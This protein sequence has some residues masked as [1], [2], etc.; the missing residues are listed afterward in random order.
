MPKTSPHRLRPQR[1]VAPVL[2]AL[3][4]AYGRPERGER[5][6]LEVLVRGILS[7]NTTDTN[8]GRAYRTLRERMPRWSDVAAADRRRIACAIRCGGLA[9]QKA[10]AI[11]N[12]MR[13]LRERDERSLDFLCD[14]GPEDAE[15]QLS[16]VKG[17]G[18]KTARLVLLFGFGW[19]VFVVDTHVHRVARRLGL[20]PDAASREKAHHL[21]DELIPDGDKYAAHLEM[22]RHGRECCHA[23]GPE[24][25]GCPVRR[26]CVFVR[27]AG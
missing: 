4:A 19:P 13:W 14:L 12:V 27:T 17:V 23:R 3:E 21:L 1:K 5:E 16:A 25:D 10:E 20:V 7:Q 11:R 18:I 9:D 26:W 6:P 22:I 24:C 8:S 2:A 15:R